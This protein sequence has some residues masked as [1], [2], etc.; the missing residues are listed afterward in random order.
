MKLRYSRHLLRQYAAAPVHVQRAFLKQI[1]LLLQNLQHPSLRTK[2]YHETLGI[3]QASVNRDW[4]FYFSIQGD[5]CR[6]HE[7]IPH[8]K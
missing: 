6:L 2:K 8:P 5:E 3:W 1:R 4:R 7:I